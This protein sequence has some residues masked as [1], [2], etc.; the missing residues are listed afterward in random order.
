MVLAF[1]VRTWTETVT[2]KRGMPAMGFEIDFDRRGS[3]MPSKAQERVEVSVIRCVSKRAW[4]SLEFAAWGEEWSAS[5]NATTRQVIRK[6]KRGVWLRK[7][8]F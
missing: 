8:A 4:H 3:E 5:I 2:S 6:R 1:E 7:D